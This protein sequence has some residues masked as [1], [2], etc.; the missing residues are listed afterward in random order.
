MGQLYDHATQDIPT[1]L[2]ATGVDDYTAQML[3]PFAFMAPATTDL[4]MPSVIEIVRAIQRSL[5]ALGANLQE[6]GQLDVQTAILI[7]QVTGPGWKSVPWYQI[8]EKIVHHADR[9]GTVRPIARPAAGVAGSMCDFAPSS[10]PGGLLGW[11]ALGGL[12][13]YLFGRKKR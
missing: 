9:G 7:Q 3:V 2:R 12:A 4:D 10:M 5:N 11:A 1:L 13:Y 8:L 6:S